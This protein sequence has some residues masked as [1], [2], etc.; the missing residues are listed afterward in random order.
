MPEN[1]KPNLFIIDRELMQNVVTWISNTVGQPVGQG[2]QLIQAISGLA[3]YT[4]AI[5][6][7]AEATPADE[8]PSDADPGPA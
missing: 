8:K 3:P 4:P 6:P 5:D 2:Y 1:Q 7:P